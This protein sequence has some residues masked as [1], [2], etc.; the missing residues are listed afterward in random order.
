MQGAAKIMEKFSS[1]TFGRIQHII[2]TVDCQ[3]T[4]DGGVLI[5]VV[6]QLKTDDDP[7]HGFFQAFVLK[8]AAAGDGFFCQ[9]DMFRL[10]IHNM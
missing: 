9:H 4:F 10:A 8:P 5:S 3:P 7:A 6:G 2:T 1:L